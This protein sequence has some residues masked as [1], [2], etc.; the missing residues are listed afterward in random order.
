MENPKEKNR[1]W[2]LAISMRTALVIGVLIHIAGFFIFKVISYPE[3]ETN[4]VKSFLV[5]AEPDTNPDSRI[6]QEQAVLFDTVPLFLPSIWNV[7]GRNN[8]YDGFQKINQP[9]L[10]SPYPEQITISENSIIPS[11]NESLTEGVSAMTLLDLQYWDF[12]TVYGL[13]ET[14]N[15]PLPRRDGYI[16]LYELRSGRLADARIIE[17]IDDSENREA[18]DLL[19][20]PMTFLVRIEYGL[21]KGEPLI[22]TDSGNEAINR[23][24]RRY[25]NET[26]PFAGLVSGN[27]RAIIGP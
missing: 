21:L 12:F 13:K 9:M 15:L 10:F 7:S 5:L 20:T 1:K 17:W 18:T 8:S 4:E 3:P 27:Y 14:P 23:K 11:L 16:E 22:I 25:L 24:M 19:W 6:L 26:F 2:V